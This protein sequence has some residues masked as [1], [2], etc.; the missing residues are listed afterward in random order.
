MKGRQSVVA[1]WANGRRGAWIQTRTT[2]SPPESMYGDASKSLLPRRARTRFQR[3]GVA[4][5]SES[6]AG[7][8]RPGLRRAEIQL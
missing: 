1:A 2:A 3:F 7:T 5:K 4:R 8:N 6:G